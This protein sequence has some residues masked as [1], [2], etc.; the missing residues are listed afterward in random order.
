MWVYWGK[1]GHL[2][3]RSQEGAVLEPQLPGA[4]WGKGGGLTRRG[5]ALAPFTGPWETLS[6]LF[7]RV[8]GSCP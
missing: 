8:L 6:W 1:L 2:E 4:Q 7:S 3:T 5:C